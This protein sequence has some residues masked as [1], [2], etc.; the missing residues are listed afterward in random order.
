MGL[1]VLLVPLGVPCLDLVEEGGLRRD[2]APKA[3]PTQMAAF[4]LGHVEPTAGL[5]SRM[6]FSFIRDS[7]RL[8]RIKSFIQR[9]FG[10]GSEMVH[11]QANFFHSVGWSHGTPMR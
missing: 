1:G 4:H 9:G 7:F 10:V 6:D 3:L 2:T 5:G 8:R 11:H